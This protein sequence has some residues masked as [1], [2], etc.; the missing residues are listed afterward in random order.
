MHIRDLTRWTYKKKVF[1]ASC[2]AR[3][4]NHPL[5]HFVIEQECKKKTKEYINISFYQ[6]AYP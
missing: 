1:I 4:I 3:V 5:F 6:I 2:Y